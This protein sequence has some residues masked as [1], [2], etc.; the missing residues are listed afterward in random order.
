M[1][2]LQTDKQKVVKILKWLLDSH[3]NKPVSLIVGDWHNPEY[4]T[5][6][7]IKLAIQWLDA[8][9]LTKHFD[10]PSWIDFG[11]WTSYSAWLLG[12]FKN[13]EEYKAWKTQN[14]R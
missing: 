11:D 13:E 9:D 12:A 1:I 14:S 3:P 6:F 10:P 8:S 5:N 2:E 7:D 4:I